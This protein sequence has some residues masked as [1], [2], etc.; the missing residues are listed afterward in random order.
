MIGRF[1]KIDLCQLGQIDDAL[2]KKC[3]RW[4]EVLTEVLENLHLVLVGTK[5]T[6]HFADQDING[7][8]QDNGASICEQERDLIL[9]VVLR[10]H[11]FDHPPQIGIVFNE[12]SVLDMGQIELRE[13]QTTHPGLADDLVVKIMLGKSP[14]KSPYPLVVA[15]HD[16]V[17]QG[18][19]TKMA[20][21]EGLR[22]EEGEFEV[23]VLID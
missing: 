15:F 12:I 20:R 3:T 16:L 8:G 13:R 22:F 5:N 2:R 4:P 1:R 23:V 14:P 6:H 18:R 11:G 19:K 10:D 17:V 7:F 9:P 21:V